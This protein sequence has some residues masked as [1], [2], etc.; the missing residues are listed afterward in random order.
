MASSKRRYHQGMFVPRNP[1]KYAGDITQ[2]KYRSGWEKKAMVFFDENP[3]VLKWGSEE[4]IIPYISPVDGR[5]HRYFPDFIVKTKSLNGMITNY[6]VEV[7][8]KAQCSPPDTKKRKTKR[9]I[10]EIQTY[11][12]NQAKWE[13][14]RAWCDNYGMKFMILTEEHLYPK[15]T[16]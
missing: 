1:D 4:V 16:R 11:S 7:K 12:V 3:N 8:P 2:I 15:G 14:A 6:M 9:L 10:E 5:P 13:A